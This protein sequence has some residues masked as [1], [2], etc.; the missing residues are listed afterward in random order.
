VAGE[1]AGR[2]PPLALFFRG[3]FR[4]PFYR[5]T[6]R[7]SLTLMI[8]ATIVLAAVWLGVWSQ[9][10]DSDAVDK[11]LRVTYWHGLL[12][13]VV[14][15]TM[16]AMAWTIVASA[17]AVTVVRETSCGADAIEHCPKLLMLE[18]MG[19]FLYVLSGLILAALP[20]LLGTPLWRWLEVSR[21]VA[22][23][24]T[25]PLLF[26]IILLSA[27]DH[28]SSVSPLS[29]AVWRS[30][31]HGWRVWLG[32]YVVTVAAAALGGGLVA[33]A[34]RYGGPVGSVLGGGTVAAIG[35]LAY[36]RLLGRLAIF[37]AGHW[38]KDGVP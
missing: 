9:T 27:L 26:P 1:A 33:A 2:M 22:I 21:P 36:F 20:G 38:A 12:L 17:Y 10:N 19:D 35:W 30:V 3:T 37:C 23:A 29:P 24:V 31:L 13:A 18:G 34:A 11:F 5:E 15:G 25:I 8:G 32:F 7:Q 14:P 6:L 28:N 16:A 4:F